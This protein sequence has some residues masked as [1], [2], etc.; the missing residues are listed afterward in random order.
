MF[1]NNRD[2]RPRLKSRNFAVQPRKLNLGRGF[3]HSFWFAGA[4]FLISEIWPRP[5]TA[6]R[7]FFTTAL[8]GCQKFKITYL[9]EKV[10]WL[11]HPFAIVTTS[12]WPKALPP[13]N[14]KSW[15]KRNQLEFQIWIW[16][17][18]L[19]LYLTISRAVTY[20]NQTPNLGLWRLT[21]VK[22]EENIFNLFE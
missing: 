2:R 7:E 11:L 18:H 14:E 1:E 16:A 22:F 10:Y 8:R 6:I 15:S 13:H 19:Y 4:D 12:S 17:A 5:R 21:I 9:T 20:S 3:C